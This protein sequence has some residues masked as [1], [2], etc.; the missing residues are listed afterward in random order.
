MQGQQ[1]IKNENGVEVHM[2]YFLHFASYI[3]YNVIREKRLETNCTDEV[4]VA[5]L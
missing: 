4:G 3:F 2:C 5:K 1:N